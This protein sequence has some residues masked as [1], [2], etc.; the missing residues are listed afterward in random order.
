[1]I[2]K[3][4]LFVRISRAVKVGG[5]LDYDR[6]AAQYDA[7][8]GGQARAGAASAAIE[9]LLRQVPVRGPASG[10]PAGLVRI[11]DLACGTGIVT[12]RLAGPGRRV[13]GIDRSAGMA[14]VAAGRLPGRIGQGD[15]TR[16]PLASGSVDVVTMV[17]LLHLLPAPAMM[18]AVAEAGRVLAPGGLLVTTVGKNDAPFSA[19]TGDDAAAILR[20]VR[21]R[22]GSRPTDALDRVAAAG[23]RY[24]LA[25]AAQ[26]TF[27]GRGQGQSPRG[28]RN[29]LAGGELRWAD[30]AGPGRVAELA[31]DLAM[32]ADQDRVRPD[33]VY[34]LAA[35]GKA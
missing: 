33:P 14:A 29:Q 16:L 12:V 9:T 13:L 19:E 15:A 7:T 23:E 28:W 1:M 17:W 6:E 10:R 22:F 24:G 31:A 8:R 2:T 3:I 18:R 21:A 20:P 30:A 27:A 4:I 34:Q 25:L 35:L 32:L 11:A 5:M 26:T